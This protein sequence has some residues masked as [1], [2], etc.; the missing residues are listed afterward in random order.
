MNIP[1]TLT[2][3]RFLLIP[4][5]GYYLYNEQFLIAACIF[6]VAGATDIAD[7]YVARKYN[8]V[9][10]WGKIADPLADKLIQITALILLTVQQ[11]ITIVI[12]IIVIAKEI[13]MGI[14][15]ILFIKEH[16]KVVG[17][18]WY[19]KLATVVL[20]IAIMFTLFRVPYNEIFI[21]IAVL[22]TLFAFAR[23]CIIFIK[24]K[25]H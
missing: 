13:L 17:A 18:N 10:D 9:T 24:M 20:F 1:N 8:M 16:K 12:L 5:F 19:G 22:V 25:N 14:G 4:I 3:I 23:Y 15:S 21:F 6:V 11:R 7:G 2:V